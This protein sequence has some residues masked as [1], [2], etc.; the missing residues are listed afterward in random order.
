MSQNLG[1]SVLI[2]FK[3]NKGSIPEREPEKRL[4][5][6]RKKDWTE[7]DGMRNEDP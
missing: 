6:P 2:L 1:F 4:P 5:H 3:Q 7:D